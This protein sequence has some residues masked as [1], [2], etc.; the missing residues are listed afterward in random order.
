MKAFHFLSVLV[1]FLIIL[2]TV[3][4]CDEE[5]PV[6][7]PLEK[8]QPAKQESSSSSDQ[9]NEVPTSSP[10]QNSEEENYKIGSLCNYCTYCKVNN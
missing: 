4:N 9:K 1:L 2:I 3:V 5:V 8:P 7:D 10:E 6:E